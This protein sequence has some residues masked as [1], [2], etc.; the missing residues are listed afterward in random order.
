MKNNQKKL[1]IIIIVI[2]IITSLFAVYLSLTIN[3]SEPIIEEPLPSVDDDTASILKTEN[4]YFA[5]QNV[6]NNYYMYISNRDN[7]NVYAVLDDKYKNDNNLTMNNIANI[8]NNNYQGVT[9]EAK[10]IYSKKLNNHRYYFVNGYLFNQSISGDIYGY[11][12]SV[13]ILVIV[14]SSNHYVIRPLGIINNLKNYADNFTENSVEVNNNKSIQFTEIREDYKLQG[15]I[16]EFINL[17][18]I[19]TERAYNML[20]NDTKNKYGNVN[21]LNNNIV[22]I[23]NNVSSSVFSYSKKEMDDYIEY[24]IK[25]KNY[26]DI[27][28][29][30]YKVMD[31]KIGFEY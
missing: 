30:E 4:M 6:I 3:N 26:H 14:N 16:S 25:D 12:K 20:D 17:L 18:S 9:Y 8:L 13:A 24:K 7:K 5:I 29:I 15:Y 28:I 10:E 31:F 23:I 19:D 27:T 2:L 22:N 11:E 21:N 1:I